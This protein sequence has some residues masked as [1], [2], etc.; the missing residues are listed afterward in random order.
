MKDDAPTILDLRDIALPDPVPAWPPAPLFWWLLGAALVATALLAWR[1]AVARRRSA[2][3]RAG[4]ARLDSLADGSDPS[5]IVAG[6]SVI[7]KRVALAAF[8]REEVA[9]L[10][11]LPWLAFLD[12]KVGGREFVTG[13]G[14]VLPRVTIEGSDATPEE[15][16]ALLALASRWI[17]RHRTGGAR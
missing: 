5:S 15:A 17:A 12:S 8:P 9:A 1:L 14:V 7:L 16:R 11:G 13:P 4:R 10:S 3:R 6:T 2:Y